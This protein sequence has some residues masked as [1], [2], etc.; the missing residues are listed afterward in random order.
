MKKNNKK[1]KKGC[2]KCGKTTGKLFV[3]HDA[4]NDKH[5]FHIKCWYEFCGWLTDRSSK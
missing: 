1:D 5:Y 4:R 2:T 3:K